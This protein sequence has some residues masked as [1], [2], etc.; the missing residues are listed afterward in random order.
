MN[1][2]LKNTFFFAVAA[3]IGCDTFTPYRHTKTVSIQ[4][5]VDKKTQLKAAKENSKG[6]HYLVEA[7]P[8]KAAIH[9]RKSAEL[10]P[11]LAA[12]HCNLGTILMGN[13]DLYRA[14]W[15]FER[16]SELA[17]TDPI[18]LINLGLVQDEGGLLEEAADYYAQAL[19][20][21][22]NNAFALGNLVRIRVKQEDDPLL[23]HQM[24]QHLIFIDSRPDWITWAEDLINTR[25]RI[26]GKSI[27]YD[28]DVKDETKRN[29]TAPPLPPSLEAIPRPP[30]TIP[31]TELDGPRVD[32]YPTGS[33]PIFELNAVV[34]TTLPYEVP[35]ESRSVER[36]IQQSFQFN[37]TAP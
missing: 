4:T 26:D 8:E 35:R 22:P 30:N 2:L 9:F 37:S 16:A 32:D 5:R 27:L 7:K 36:G 28:T 20:L 31:P 15:E 6:V 13:H 29:L 12:P 11:A 10:D 18:P 34:Q 17:P 3:C 19:E 24:L 25:Y 33:I 23:I 1:D 21:D 14:A